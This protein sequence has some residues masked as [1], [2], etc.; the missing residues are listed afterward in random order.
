MA[1]GLPSRV[2]RRS[3]NRSEHQHGG[4]RAH[5][6][7]PRNRSRQHVPFFGYQACVLR[8]QPRTWA[9]RSRH[10]SPERRDPG[11][12]RLRHPDSQGPVARVFR[13]HRAICLRLR[14]IRGNLVGDSF[15]NAEALLRDFRN[16][17]ILIGDFRTSGGQLGGPVLML[18]AQG[19][20][21]MGGFD[22][23]LKVDSQGGLG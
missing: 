18:M 19:A 3:S 17:A 1:R 8:S 6:L 20:R 7:R 21:S 4:E 9:A 11:R 5:D 15:P 10:R 14:R 13:A 23:W 22:M 16:K 12:R 2:W